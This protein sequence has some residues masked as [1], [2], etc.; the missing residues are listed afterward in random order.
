MQPPTLNSKRR[1][2]PV[3]P[4]RKVLDSGAHTPALDRAL[5]L[6]EMLSS[7][8][9]GSSPADIRASLG[10]SANLVFRLTK[11]LLA[12]GYL[13]R[14]P[15]G[16]QYVLS[17]KML[18]LSQPRREERSLVQ[19]ALETMRWLRDVT[20]E[21]AHIGVRSEFECIVLDRVIGPNPF[22]CYVEAGAR[23]PLHTGAPGKVLLAWL[24]EVELSRVLSEMPLARLTARSITCPVK[25][26]RHLRKVRRQGYALDLGEGIEGHHCIGAPVFDG[27][28]RPIA[29]VWITAPAPRI[30]VR[31]QER[32]APFVREAG[33]RVSEAMQN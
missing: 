15:V 30:R 1:K 24:P 8:P 11:S 31:D 20:G 27:E 13:D 6:L 17:R 3:C 33:R 32:L 7:R 16:N 9:E 12:H 5:A 18:T 29:A 23:G 28:Q 25:L 19:L 26:Q 2:S 22:K 4:V 14:L 21:S 10:F